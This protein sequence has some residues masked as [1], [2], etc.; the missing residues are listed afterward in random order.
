MKIKNPKTVA[1]LLNN[2]IN[3][4]FNYLQTGKEKITEC[5]NYIEGLIKSDEAKLINKIDAMRC[6]QTLKNSERNKNLYGSTLGT[7]LTGIK[8]Y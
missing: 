3:T 5:T 6:I 4:I 8:C 1:A 7:W 2:H